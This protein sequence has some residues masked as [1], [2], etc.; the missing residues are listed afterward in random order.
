MY[1]YLHENGNYIKKPDRVV[2]GLSGEI[3]P[4]IYFEGP[5]VQKW[6]KF[7]TEEEANEFITQNKS[8]TYFG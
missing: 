1:V 6:W 2:E 3:G 8:Q 4:E 7:L 5:M